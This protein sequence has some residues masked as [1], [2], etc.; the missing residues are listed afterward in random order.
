RAVEDTSSPGSGIGRMFH[1][2]M[3]PMLNQGLETAYHTAID[4]AVFNSINY[5]PNG[6]GW[7]DAFHEL[8]M[9]RYVFTK[10]HE[11]EKQRA[12]EEGRD[13]KSFAETVT[14]SVWDAYR[15]RVVNNIGM[16]FARNVV[17]GKLSK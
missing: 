11:I 15:R 13:A 6:I 12:L 3:M 9:Q 14:S 7:G 4:Y 10:M 2:A 8:T 17:I 5:A 1:V 16:N